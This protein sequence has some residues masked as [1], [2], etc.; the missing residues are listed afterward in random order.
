MS[1]ARPISR[2]LSKAL[3]LSVPPSAT[4]A[5]TKRYIK[6]LKAAEISWAN[7]KELGF[8]TNSD[9]HHILLWPYQHDSIDSLLTTLT[10]EVVHIVEDTL[11]EGAVETV[12]LALMKSPDWRGHVAHRIAQEFFAFLLRAR[13]KGVLIG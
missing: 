7:G 2:G 4:A 9:D 1:K 13:K 5:K 6:A 3:A 11:P 8:V 10:H 12:T